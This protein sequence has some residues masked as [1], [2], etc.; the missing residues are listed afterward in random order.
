MSRC[1]KR[2]AT[3]PFR[4]SP[5]GAT[6]IERAW[7]AAL[8]LSRTCHCEDQL[9]PRP[10][11][12]AALRACDFGAATRASLRVQLRLGQANH[13][14]SMYRMRRSAWVEVFIHSAGTGDGVSYLPAP[15]G[16]L[17]RQRIV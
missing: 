4:S 13:D 9:C 14:S 3:Q 12:D 17:S 7:Q 15:A 8:I 5:T 16:D 10:Q 6:V 11:L 2:R 1:G